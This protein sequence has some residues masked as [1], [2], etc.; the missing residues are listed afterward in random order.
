MSN[1][2]IETK[3]VVVDVR[4]KFCPTPVIETKK[5][6]DGNPSAVV[7]TI[8]DNEVSRDNVEK[9][10]K[11]RG[12][13]VTIS[14]TEDT[15]HVLLIPSTAAEQVVTG[16]SEVNMGSAAG[17]VQSAGG[18]Q[19]VGSPMATKGKVLVISKEFVG[20]GSEELGRTLMKTFLFS[21]TE[22]DCMPSKIFFLNGGVKM[23]VEGSEHLDN[24][25]QL[26]NQG[27]EIASCGI[28]LNYYELTEKLAIGSVTNMYVIA[29]ALLGEEAILL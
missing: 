10:G 13:T 7:E 1:K 22:V 17:V 8:V 25:Q 3:P 14:E 6:I 15:F 24:L 12:Y 19:F 27:V 2:D 21:L 23:A 9:F 20:Q 29:N 18:T 5:I 11:S 16:T 4:G 26:I 28:C